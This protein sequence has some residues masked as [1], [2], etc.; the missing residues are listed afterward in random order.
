MR[1]T[2]LSK[3]GLSESLLSVFEHCYDPSCTMPICYGSCGGLRAFVRTKQ[4]NHAPHYFAPGCVCVTCLSKVGL[5]ESLLSVFEH[6]YD[7][8]CTMPICYGS[9]GGLR[10]F[11]RTKQINHAPHY[12]APGCVS[13]FWS[14]CR[15]TIVRVDICQDCK[16]RYKNPGIFP[17]FE[18]LKLMMARTKCYQFPKKKR[19]VWRM[20]LRR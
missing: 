13:F 15:P 12:F 14:P 11:V 5:S 10:A 7:P 17:E 16:L 19:F 20:L 6:C 1:V 3:V 9:C 2:C 8:S 4:I 18:M